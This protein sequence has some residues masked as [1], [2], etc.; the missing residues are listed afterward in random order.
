[1]DSDIGGILEI[2][3]VGTRRK[4]SLFCVHLQDT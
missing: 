2:F 4:N 1:M 3:G